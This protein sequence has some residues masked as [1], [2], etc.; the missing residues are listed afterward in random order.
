[1]NRKWNTQ[2]QEN[3]YAN[4]EITMKG[5]QILNII[6]VLEEWKKVIE[7]FIQEYHMLLHQEKVEK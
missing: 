5:R 3:Y 6:E 7:S 2:P 1:M 4:K